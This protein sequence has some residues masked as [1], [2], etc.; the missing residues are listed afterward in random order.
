MFTASNVRGAALSI[1][2][3]SHKDNSLEN[4][5]QTLHT[6]KLA[7]AKAYVADF[8][9]LV[10]E[11][12][13]ELTFVGTGFAFGLIKTKL[14]AQFL[15]SVEFIHPNLDIRGKKEDPAE[16]LSNENLKRISSDFNYILGLVL[17]K[18]DIDNNALECTFKIQM[19]KK[20]SSAYNLNH[21][22][23]PESKVVFGNVT[24]LQLNG[25]GVKM[26]ENIFG[27]QVESI[28]H[29]DEFQSKDN[30]NHHD[31]NANFKFKSSGPIDFSKFVTESTNRINDLARNIVGNAHESQK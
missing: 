9:D 23:A 31:V 15:R 8:S 24:D 10:G 16:I 13:S 28:Y 27:T 3:P 22:L 21:L 14:V 29:I 18:M 20:V 12:I 25:I 6:R 2:L 4:I 11:V 17:G 5:V 1:S 30:K 19:S 7:T 26:V